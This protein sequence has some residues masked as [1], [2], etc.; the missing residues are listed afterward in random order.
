MKLCPNCE[1]YAVRLATEYCCDKCSIYFN[2]NEIKIFVTINEK[3]SVCYFFNKHKGTAKIFQANE[4]SNLRWI[5]KTIKVIECS[6][7]NFKNRL[8]FINK[9]KTYMLFGN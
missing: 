2:K 5:S 1:S 9:I 3:L 7:L 6:P 4:G 8:E